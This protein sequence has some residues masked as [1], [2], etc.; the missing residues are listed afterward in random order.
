[1]SA[2]GLAA[3]ERKMRERGLDEIRVRNFG[4]AYRQLEEENPGLLPDAELEP[5]AEL[6]RLVHLPDATAGDRE[7]LDQVVVIRL[8]GGLGTSMGVQ[9]PKSL[10]E[11]REGLSFLDIIVDQVLALRE[12][13]G[14]RLPLVLMNSF[15]TREATERALAVH[16]EVEADLPLEFLQGAVPKLRAD[17]LEPVRWPADPELEWAPPGHGDLYTSLHATGMLDRMLEAGYRYAFVANSDNLGATVDARIPAQMRAEAIPFLMEAARGTEADRKGGHIARRRSDGRLVLRETA[18]VP[19]DE[20]ESFSDF[21]RWRFYNTNTL[22]LDLQALHDLLERDGAIELPLIVN[23]KTVDPRDKASTPVIQ[24]ESAMGAAIASFPGAQALEV[25][26]TRFAPVKTT[27]D[28]LLIRSD[29]YRFGDLLAVEP[30]PDRVGRLPFIDLDRRHYALLDEF[31]AR[32]PDGPPSLV[33]AERLVVRGDVTFPAGVAIVGGVTI[34]NSARAPLVLEP[35]AVIE[36]NGS[37]RV[38]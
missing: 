17:N 37:A 20:I 18:Q 6:P 28:L 5:V 7:T 15:A 13:Q 27:D 16:P 36:A 29:V 26:R 11:A 25:P 12:R 34:D 31:E 19:P 22:W 9:E 8:N 3:A 35:G 1:M 10:I 4:R 24:L 38:P 23:R 2:E 21:R 14:I 33:E 30:V 32:F